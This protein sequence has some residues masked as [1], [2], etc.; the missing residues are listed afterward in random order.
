MHFHG[1]AKRWLSSVEE[2]L[3]STTWEEFCAQLLSRFARDEHEMLLRRLFQ[4]RQTGSVNE[5]IYAF[6]ALV[7]QLKAYAKHPDPLY[8]TQRFIDGL[9]DEIK[10]VVLVQRPSSLDTACVLSLLQEEALSVIRRP[11]RRAEHMKPGWTGALPLPAPPLKPD[12]G[13]IKRLAD[14]PHSIAEEKFQALRASR[15]AR[16]LC[17]RCGAKWSR[18]HKCAEV[19]QLHH[20]QELLDMFPDH[21]EAD[22]TS[23][24]STIAQ[25]MLH[26]SIAAVAGAAA[27]K[28]LCLTGAIQ[29]HS[30]S[31][32]V[33]SGSSHTFLSASLAQSLQGVQQLPQP[34]HVQVANGA[35]LQC[36]SYILSTTWSVQGFS[37]TNDLKLLELS[38]FDMILGLDW[39]SG[40]SPMHVH[41]AQKWISIPYGDSTALLFGDDSS[42]PVG[43]VVQLCMVQEASSSPAA[44]QVHLPPA[45]QALISE[46][47]S[48]FEPPSG[49]PPSRDCDHSIPLIPGAQPVF[50]RPYRYA[51]LLK[52]EIERQVTDMLQQGIIQKSS[53]AFASPVL[54]VKKKD[55][56]WRFCVD[57]RHLNAITVKGKYPVPII[58]ELL[59]ELEGADWFTSLDLQAGFHQIRM[60]SGEEFKTAFLTHFGQF[61][62]RVMS[63]G[64]TGAPGTFQD[65]MNTTLHPYLRK[66][67]IVFFD[68]ILIYSATLSEHLEHL[69]LVFE[70]LAKAHWKLKMTKCSFAQNKIAYLGHIISAEGVSTDPAKLEAI[71]QWPSPVSVKD[72]RSF[73]GLAGYY[74]RFVRH[75]GILSKPLTN[76]LKKN[77]LFIWT[78]DHENAF[79]ALK[80]ALCQSPVLALPNFAKP[81]SI[82]TDASDAGVGA[83]LM[84]DG[85]PLAFFS[86]ALGPRSR[87]LSTYEKEFLAILLAVHNW[88]SYLQFQEFTI[89]TDHRSLTQ[90]GDQRLHTHWQQL[91]FSKLLG[92]QYRIIYRPGSSNRA[93]DALSRHPAPPAVCAAVSTL[94]PSWISAVQ[95]SYTEDSTAK[96]MLSKLAL[97]PSA[98]PHFSLHSGLL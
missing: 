20:V 86:K 9:R 7:D 15:R 58:E 44:P 11:F 53:S 87:G 62:F 93:A 67:V 42:L 63:F 41:W 13:D 68:D 96:E 70:L 97:D 73:L 22:D 89:L 45:V 10:A 54:L 82:E 57:Y 46:F 24:D 1:A 88:R 60:K 52:T 19:V 61:E 76:L 55:N 94:V 65:A 48:L 59:D 39:L 17:I 51:P 75:F 34:V 31:I 40:F 18:D 85:H 6:L 37:F 14:A 30:I 74:R 2:Q 50:V 3:E 84:Q 38:S 32:L 4:I 12:T 64:L 80:S 23:P 98:I 8:Y 49:L 35:I 92:L 77:S 16:G 56:T 78:V 81:F 29:G 28:T 43:S 69:R 71:S 21:D 66:F 95:A 36:T 33:D 47:A 25:V 83:V 72:L 79:Q 26:L 5:Y 90:L 91:V 27:P